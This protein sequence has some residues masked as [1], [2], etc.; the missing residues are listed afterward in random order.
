MTTNV[1]VIG[2]HNLL[3]SSLCRWLEARLPACHPFEAMSVAEGVDFA[4]RYV[5]QMII[6]D[7]G[8]PGMSSLKDI[9]NIKTAVPTTPLVVLITYDYAPYQAEAIAAGARACLPKDAIHTELQPLLTGL[10]SG[11]PQN[12]RQAQLDELSVQAVVK[13]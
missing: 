4:Q 12:G 6:L 9:V 8:F 1:L 13:I 5:P 7:A 11:Q 10:L 3:R 2:E